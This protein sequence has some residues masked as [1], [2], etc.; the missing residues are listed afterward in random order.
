SLDADEEALRTRCERLVKK[1]KGDARRNRNQ[2]E[3]IDDTN[4]YGVLAAEGFLPG[5]GLDTGAET[6]THVA[7]RHSSDINDW[8]LRR[9]TTLTVR[10]Y[11]PCKLIYVDDYIFDPRQFHLV[12]EEPLVFA[13]DVASESVQ[14]TGPSTKADSGASSMAVTQIPGVAICDV[15]APHHSYISDDEDYRFQMAVA[16]FAQD[17]GRHSGGK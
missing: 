13:V 7:P 14:E 15:D 17:Q 11:V 6:L 12:P 5:Y 3:G 2:A 16:V 9:N 4:T 10:E 1:L 8:E